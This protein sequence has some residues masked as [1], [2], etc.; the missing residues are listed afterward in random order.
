VIPGLFSAVPAVRAQA[1]LAWPWF[2]G[3]LVPAG[4][5]FALDGVLIGAGDVRFLRNMTLLSTLGGFL[6]V[7][8]LASAYRLGSGGVWAGPAV[9]TLVRLVLVGL[10]QRSG[11]WAG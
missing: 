5:V 3:L 2:V 7:V 9:F 11:R 4:V 1:M 8:W 10:R 6:P